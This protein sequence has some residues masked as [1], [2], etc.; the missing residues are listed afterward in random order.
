MGP[1]PNLWPAMWI[2]WHNMCKVPCTTPGIQQMKDT[3]YN[4]VHLKSIWNFWPPFGM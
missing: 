4:R 1:G 3:T 2:K